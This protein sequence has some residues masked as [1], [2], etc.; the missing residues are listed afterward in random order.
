MKHLFQQLHLKTSALILGASLALGG[1]ANSPYSLPGAAPSR[2]APAQ[3]AAGGADPRLTNNDE[4]RFFSKSGWQACAGGALVGALACQIGNP[5]DKKDCMLKAAL[6]G[7]GVAMGANYYLDQRRSEYSNTET[8]LNTM[9]ADV[10]EDNRKL[11]SLT[12][13]AR[14][15]MAEDRQQIAQLQK[16]IAAKRVQKEQARKQV[17]EIDANTQYLRKSLADLKSREQ[18][19]RQVA[20]SE[21]SSGARVDTLDAEINRMQQQIASLESEINELYQQRSA[22]QL[23]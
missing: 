17:A 11:Q 15:V 22:I 13:T 20:A 23:G 21:R 7:C 2:A 5:S 16:D 10:R 3:A 12:Q 1:C 9:I 8:R 6:V 4:A 19:W 14:T 18:Q